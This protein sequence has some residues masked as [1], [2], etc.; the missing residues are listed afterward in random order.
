MWSTRNMTSWGVSVSKWGIPVYCISQV[1]HLIAIYSD[2]E[3]P[4]SGNLTC[5]PSK[6]GVFHFSWLCPFG[7]YICLKTLLRGARVILF[8]LLCSGNVFL[9]RQLPY[10]WGKQFGPTL[11][12]YYSIVYPTIPM[13]LNAFPDGPWPPL[14]TDPNTC[15]RNVRIQSNAQSMVQRWPQVMRTK[16]LPRRKNRDKT[17]HWP[18]KHCF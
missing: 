5:R 10:L 17:L 15:S 8:F 2:N 16:R 11:Q 3:P 7:P 9:L 18:I 6:S 13:D 4:N 14:R 1:A 12:P